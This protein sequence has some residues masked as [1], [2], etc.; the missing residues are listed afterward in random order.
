MTLTFTGAGTGVAAS[1]ANQP[2][3]TTTAFAVGDY[4]VAL[5]AYDNSGG[6]GADPLSGTI[7]LSIPTGAVGA[8]VGGQNGLNDPGAASAGLCTRVVAFPVITAIPSGTVVTVLW[9]G[10]TIV[11]RAAVLG[12]VSVSSP[13]NL[14]AY[15]TNNT[16]VNA[17]ATAAP[18]YTTGTLVNATEMM[19]AWA[20][21]ENG[22]AVTGATNST[23]GAWGAVYGTFQGSAQTG[24]AAYFQ[25]KVA[26]STSAMTFNPTGTLSDWVMG[27]LVFTETLVPSIEQAAY[28][29]FDDAGTEAGA[30]SLAAVNT[31]ITGNLAAGDGY[32]VLRT[33]LQSTTG[34]D[35]GATDDFQLQYERTSGG[36]A[37]SRG[38]EHLE[39]SWDESNYTQNETLCLNSTAMSQALGQTFTGNGQWLTKVG[40]YMR[41]AGT[42]TG[43]ITAQLYEAYTMSV[44][45]ATT[46]TAP[47]NVAN[48]TTTLGWYEF[49]FDPYYLI[50]GRVYIIGFQAP[51][52]SS[53]SNV[54]YLGESYNAG[55]ASAGP[56]ALAFWT[57]GT[58]PYWGGSGNNDLMHRIY[59]QDSWVDANKGT[60]VLVDSYSETNADTVQNLGYAGVPIRVAQSFLGTGKKLSKA[61]M[62]L[63]RVSAP[64]GSWG[65]TVMGHTG[66]FGSGAVPDGGSLTWTDSATP[67]QAIQN[68]FGWIDLPLIWPGPGTGY[69]PAVGERLFLTL[70]HS[71][72]AS[73][74]SIC[75]QTMYDASA[76]TH[77]GNGAN[78][79]GAGPYAAQTYD[80]PFR[81]YALDTP[82]VPYDNPNL[83]DGAATTNR[84]G[85]GS[86]T[87]V[88]GKISE[89]SDVPNMGWSGNN[90][91]ELVYSLKLAAAFLAAGDVLR[92]RVLRNGSTARMTY[93]QTPTINIITGPG[94]VALAGVSGGVSATSATM[95]AGP[96]PGV[97][98]VGWWDA[99]DTSTFTYSSGAIVSQWSD[100]SPTPHHAVVDGGL[101]ANWVPSRETNVING[102]AAVYFNGAAALRST[103]SAGQSPLT[104]IALIKLTDVSDYRTWVGGSG[105]GGFQIRADQ[106]NASVR[107][108]AGGLQGIAVSAVPLPVAQTVIVTHT[109]DLAGS[110]AFW[111]NGVDAGSGSLAPVSLTATDTRFGVHMAGGEP[112]L[113]HIGEIIKYDRVL[114]TTERQQVEGYLS[115]KWIPPP[116]PVDLT[117]GASGGLAATSATMRT[118]D[119][120][121][122]ASAGVATVPTV[123]VNTFAVARPL[124]ATTT[125]GAA[126]VTNSD[127]SVV[128]APVVLVGS[129]AG[130]AATTT[131]AT[132]PLVARALVGSSAGLS[133]NTTTATAPAVTHPLAATAIAG[134]ATTVAA[135]DVAAPAGVAVPLAA[136]VA[137]TST[138]TATT[139]LVT[140]GLTAG[141]AGV[142]AVTSAVT[143][144]LPLA[145]SSA[146]TST[147]TATPTVNR[148]VI[149]AAG[150]AATAAAT[151]TATTLPLTAT[152]AGT[153]TAA[154]TT[155]AVARP[156]AAAAAGVTGTSAG[157]LV[158]G[159]GGMSAF[160]PGTSTATATTLGV[161]RP[162]TAA[163]N[164]LATGAASTTAMTRTLTGATGGLSA[165]VSNVK[166]DRGVNATTGGASTAVGGFVIATRLGTAASV[167]QAAASGTLTAFTPGGIY[168]WWNGQ[169]VIAMN[170]GGQPVADWL[171]TAPV[172]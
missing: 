107:T 120:L 85:A 72:A 31:P 115:T 136:T 82:V 157:V 52:G 44:V 76:S 152:A 63:G 68:G 78:Y 123:P 133:T 103:M 54:V 151:T 24:M 64:S 113:G 130:T 38:V 91:T 25:P 70:T 49:T 30:A 164:G 57:A 32:G 163:A 153:S 141:S 62:W 37:V 41:K 61:G 3:T 148:G 10:A 94:P 101:P 66:T 13:A 97:G 121:I 145:A 2:V 102:R 100:K 48:L 22:A 83:T 139:T 147:V 81:V 74:A 40:F 125:A 138:T 155:A 96:I 7:T 6:G 117:A 17:V 34:S 55:G 79:I 161:G 131:T 4:L 154:M 171:L 150:G 99:D 9:A 42:P 108:L 46:T 59:T 23:G 65:L 149:G 111:F 80:F 158:S 170:W 159:A 166:V 45:M 132:A 75:L 87:F 168:G 60:E 140:R 58:P 167:G 77:A 20:G 28:Q 69:T 160:V 118:A 165:P 51:S 126:T 95:F 33:R 112:M 116:G 5:I 67:T 88:A 86:G 1:G 14:I 92:F 128:K 134:Q 156:L 106:T 162:L 110:Y 90:Y 109:Y 89:T 16:P 15:R 119:A 93:T 169:A 53:A 56:G 84:L 18:T 144:T 146:A 36:T 114:T 135:L 12:K 50:P 39:I 43:T 8:G 124:A 11:V 98:L 142:S 21:H 26:T 19:L 129:S 73:S 127:L 143:A 27:H 29:F 104:L 105:A 137:G 47:L 122:G 71:N 35:I 172:G